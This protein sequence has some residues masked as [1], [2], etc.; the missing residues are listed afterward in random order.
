MKLR[1]IMKYAHQHIA[2]GCVLAALLVLTP[3][4]SGKQLES[5]KRGEAIAVV[6]EKGPVIDGTMSDP[7]WSQCKP[8]PMGDCLSKDPLKHKT[9]AKVLFD[10][11]NIYVGVYCTEPN[12]DGMIVEGTKHDDSVWNG[13]SV[14][15]FL[16][17]DPGQ[18]CSQF[19]VNPRGVLYDAQDKRAEWNS[20]AKAVASIDQGKAWTAVLRIPLKNLPAYVG[21]DQTWTMNI[22][23]TRPERHGDKTLM[24]S[25]SIMREAD[26][27]AVS[28]FGV[29]AG[30][31][32]PR[33]SDGVTRVLAE[34]VPQPTAPNRGQ[35]RGGVKV[36][37]RIDFAA[38][39]GGFKGG[40]GS[41]AKLT[42]NAVD[43]KALRVDCQK[44][45]GGC[46][47][48][49]S[50]AGSRGLKIAVMMKGGKIDRAGINVYDT[51]A[52]DN[53]T[54]YGYRYF[55]DGWTPVVY[56][57]EGFR[58]N[59]RDRGFVAPNTNYRSVR[60]FGPQR[61]PPG[62]W[63][64]LDNF[65][66]YRGD[67]RQPPAK[68]TGLSSKPTPRG[69]ALSWDA[70]EDN[71]MPMV[72]VVARA[73]NGV[74]RKIAESYTSSHVDTTA[75]KGRYRYRVFAIDFEENFGP[76][77]DQVEVRSISVPREPK[78]NRDQQDRLRY[79]DHVRKVHAR[80]RNEV[81]R[82]HA[83]L[84]GDSLTAATVYP[85]CARSAFGNL[86]IN[87]FGYPSMRTS[88]ARNKVREILE[89][90]NPEFMFVLYGTNNNKVDKHIPAAMD[91][92]AAVVKACEDRG[93]V[94][95]LGTIPPRGWSPESAPEANF[96]RHIIELC[97]KLK[98]P[99]GYIFE[100]FQEAGSQSRRT[101]MGNDGVH[102]R[103]EGMAIGGRAWAKALDQ[104]RFVIRDQK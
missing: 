8:W 7:L 19:V 37:H 79:A 82:N 23:R 99:T 27:H 74:F 91:D 1:S 52:R 98:I 41:S 20:T 102:W 53:T 84:F 67:D 49:I 80:G 51:I 17:P 4:V 65:A 83:T 71:V 61:L 89:K 29:V 60:F 95:I 64:T 57:L 94:P 48:P 85:Q 70:A 103:G 42:D 81:R 18:P 97:R 14:E 34:G 40:N 100:G 72:Y 26:Y 47:L 58:Y 69:V 73:D 13:D 24:Y 56:F 3:C 66:I 55:K 86:T 10:P 21:E 104:I 35:Q 46:E 15:V 38:G 77:S 96:N 76:W 6:I 2:R 30:V 25:W 32:I 59:S 33:R 50:I 54:A 88:F 62:S 90:D 63:F 16:R 68:V 5:P 43:G 45:W 92:L 75:G 78:P 36:Y 101:Y 31:D 39:S 28:Q 12:T 44:G 87:A 9:W 93:T 22:Y 11:T